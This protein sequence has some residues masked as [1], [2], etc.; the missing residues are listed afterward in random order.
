MTP[1]D[2]KS[3]RDLQVKEGKAE[4]TA[5]LALKTLRS[6]FNDARREGLISTNPA[7]AVVTFGTEKEARDV[8]THE[9]LCALMTKA[10]PEWKTAILLAYYSGLRLRDAVSLTWENV[11][12]ELRQIR[13]FPRKSN[14]RR[15][16]TVSWEAAKC[17]G[18]TGRSMSPV[19]WKS[20]RCPKL[21]HICCR[22]QAVTLLKR[23]FVRRLGLRAPA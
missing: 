5:D 16:Q 17:A 15:S 3:F 8:F 1:Q 23:N 12:F 7:E 11:N 13:Y 20:R 18:R 9:Q 21:R 10:S 4:T 6:L 2:V 14:R 22:C 19:N